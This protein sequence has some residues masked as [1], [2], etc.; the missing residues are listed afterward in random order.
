[1]QN[2]LRMAGVTTAGQ[3]RAG[4]AL[5]V[6][7]CDLIHIASFQVSTALGL[8]G[9]IASTELAYEVNEL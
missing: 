7:A 5:R 3:E 1:M 6:D 4:H 8:C 2:R 9:R